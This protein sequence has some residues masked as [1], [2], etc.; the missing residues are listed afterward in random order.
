MAKFDCIL[1]IFG[2]PSVCAEEGYIRFVGKL[3]GG[4]K[5]VGVFTEILIGMYD[6][7]AKARGNFVEEIVPIID[8]DMSAQCRCYVEKI[9][10][11]RRQGISRQSLFDQVAQAAVCEVAWF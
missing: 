11:I 6:H 7:I 8:K 3:E 9:L 2:E 4:V 10:H 1:G 5:R